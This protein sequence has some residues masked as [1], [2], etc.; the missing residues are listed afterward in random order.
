MPSLQIAKYKLCISTLSR[1]YSRASKHQRHQKIQEVSSS[2]DLTHSSFSN[3]CRLNRNPRRNPADP[4]RKVQVQNMGNTFG[5]R[6]TCFWGCLVCA[7]WKRRC[8]AGAL[9]NEPWRRGV[10]STEGAIGQ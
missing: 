6:V 1:F 10:L 3:I 9:L 8:F 4:V 5:F 2:N 7:F